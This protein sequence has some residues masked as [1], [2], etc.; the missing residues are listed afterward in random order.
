MFEYVNDYLKTEVAMF[1]SRVYIWISL[2]LRFFGFRRW[3]NA[4][5]IASFDVLNYDIN[6]WIPDAQGIVE[7]IIEEP[8]A[9]SIESLY[10]R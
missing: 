8:E 2:T 6:W 7:E 10:V 9:S 3:A 1:E 4:M 5:Q